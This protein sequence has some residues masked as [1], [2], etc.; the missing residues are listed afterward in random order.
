M[1]VVNLFKCWSRVKLILIEILISLALNLPL[2]F[3][4]ADQDEPLVLLLGCAGPLGPP[5]M[6][7]GG[8]TV[9]WLG[10]RL[11]MLHGQ[12]RGH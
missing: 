1:G 7:W 6:M 10:C 5:Y 3:P 11:M 4:F 8:L 2:S 9:A 12:I